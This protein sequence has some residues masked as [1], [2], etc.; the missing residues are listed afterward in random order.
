MNPELCGGFPGGVITAAGASGISSEEDNAAEVS[1]GCERRTA[2]PPPLKPTDGVT[3]AGHKT[4][5]S[6]PKSALDSAPPLHA[7]VR[8]QKASVQPPCWVR[9]GQTWWVRKAL[10]EVWE[11]L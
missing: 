2:S 9:E 10:E 4:D 11:L 7:G 3:P 5:G 1:E 6:Y 8:V